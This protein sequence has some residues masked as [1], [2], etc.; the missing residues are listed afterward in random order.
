M[1]GHIQ[2]SGIND[3]NDFLD[4]LWVLERDLNTL[5]P[6]MMIGMDKVATSQVRQLLEKLG[7][8]TLTGRD[9]IHHHILPILTNDTVWKVI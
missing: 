8:K 5:H 4:P 7:V 6:A 9:V 3:F 1:Y 2:G